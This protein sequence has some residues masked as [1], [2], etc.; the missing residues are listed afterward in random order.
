MTGVTG[1]DYPT[2]II[3]WSR[4][5]S[6]SFKKI[7]REMSH[8]RSEMIRL[9]EESRLLY[10]YYEYLRSENRKLEQWTSLEKK[11]ALLV[12]SIRKQLKSH[13]LKPMTSFYDQQYRIQPHVFPIPFYV[14]TSN[15]YWNYHCYRYCV[16][17]YTN[18]MLPHYTKQKQ[19][20]R[21]I[22]RKIERE[23][24]RYKDIYPISESEEQVN[25]G[26]IP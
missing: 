11:G 2:M 22:H 16:M 23:L 8:L 5:F 14:W 4:S 3:Q 6:V 19:W 18:I 13:T 26:V 7:C 15:I 9:G 10:S 12:P 1:M 24:E 17:Y 21:M 25:M 20:I